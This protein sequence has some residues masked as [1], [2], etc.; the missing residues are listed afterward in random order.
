MTE[1]FLTYFAN[2]VALNKDGDLLVT[3]GLSGG[4]ILW[5]DR[6]EGGYS[7]FGHAGG[8]SEIHSVQFP[9]RHCRG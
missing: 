3:A 7:Q 6:G 1:P 2:S 8:S 5:K 9:L 4:A